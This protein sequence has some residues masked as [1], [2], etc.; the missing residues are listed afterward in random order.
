MS[1][2]F[3]IALTLIASTATAMPFFPSP[4]ALVEAVD[5][6]SSRVG[7]QV[8]VEGHLVADFFRDIYL[9]TSPLSAPGRGLRVRSD[10]HLGEVGDL[11]RVFGKPTLREGELYL[12]A[13][14][15][16]VLG[17]DARI[18]Y[19]DVDAALLARD[20]LTHA[21]ALVRLRNLE[22]ERLLRDVNGLPWLAVCR[23]G[24]FTVDVE[25][26]D[27]AHPVLL[28]GQ[29]ID[30]LRGIYKRSRE[31]WRVA[32]RSTYDFDLPEAEDPCPSTILPDGR[33]DAPLLLDE[34]CYDPAGPGEAEGA[35]SFAVVNTGEEVFDLTGWTVTDGEGSWTF[36][37]GR[38]LAP[39]ERFRIARHKERYFFEFGRDC[40][41]SFDRDP[42]PRSDCLVLYNGGD[43][44]ML[45]GPDGAQADCV[46]FGDYRLRRSADAGWKGERARPFRFSEYVPTEGAVLQR[47]RDPETGR[48]LDSDTAE[49]WIGDPDDADWGRQLS[50]A[51]WDR[52][53][54]YDT[55][56][57]EAEAEIRAYVS[58]EHSFEGVRDFL[59]SATRS[60][61]IEI[62]LITHPLVVDEL[63]AAMERGVAV[64]V[65]LDGEVFGA[66]G[67]T[68][69]TVRG[70]MSRISEHPSG[71]GR[72]YFWRNGDDPR[73]L[74][75]DGDIPDRYNHVHQK[76]VLV[77]R[78]RLLVGS[79]NFTQSSLPADDKIN[80][81]GGSRGVFLVTDAEC[82]VERA[83]RI[84]EADFDPDH[85]RDVR[86][87][88]QNP[89]LEESLPSLSGDRYGYTALHPAPF[90]SRER[91]S[92]ELSQS[93][94]NSMRP[95]RGY[96]GLVARAGAGDWIFVEQQYERPHW[97]YG[98]EQRPNPR[99]EAY[100]EAARRG[101][102]VRIIL[103]GN[104]PSAK[105]EA[106][107]AIIAAAAA[108][109]LDIKLLPGWLPRGRSR[110]EPIH[111]KM[112]LARLGEE[113]WS[114]VGS[115][116]GS[117]TASL[118]NRELGLSVSSEGL[119]EYLLD[120]F[121]ADWSQAGGSADELP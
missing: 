55:A 105:S 37:G 61:E 106:T 81:T 63:I 70:L 23:Q 104:R 5:A 54:F 95:D 74:G 43:E 66:F 110:R 4:N 103:S 6:D 33:L 84:W 48:L 101:A 17:F 80:G 22:V 11:V 51:G 57:C 45:L 50:F 85:H 40:D 117:E 47:K 108:E 94:D 31:H 18:A 16:Q 32:P 24:D 72:V 7:A 10:E 62:Y 58:P 109:G 71:R 38:L 97:G 90:V 78:E 14:S 76:F 113:R 28:E 98:R 121:R 53:I 15:L 83:I 69:D 115:A 39:G 82:V 3:M 119:H 88:F 120:V 102:R 46:Q 73:H 107:G 25:L 8:E 52:E 2:R 35:E 100:L 44:L 12:D 36:P 65:L 79:D 19:H 118:F 114:H 96:L 20:S 93:P 59:R 89:R 77:D 92:F 116:N 34:I 9:Q 1:A 21:D 111:N 29:R 86:R 112:L 60:I 68:Y 42:D 87:H 41:F 13:D 26:R 56:R 49:D 67:G 30:M 75:P 27:G 99:V 91:A 64:T